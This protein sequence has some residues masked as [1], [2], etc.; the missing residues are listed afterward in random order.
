MELAWADLERRENGIGAGAAGVSATNWWGDV[1]QFLSPTIL[2][3]RTATF[4]HLPSHRD[5]YFIQL[6]ARLKLN[7][8]AGRAP[9]AGPDGIWPVA[10][11]FSSIEKWSFSDP[12]SQD[13][14]GCQ[15]REGHKML[16]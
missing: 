16:Q 2:D 8:L 6:R 7:R 9:A 14:S 5:F 15:S 11:L 13:L 10:P 3:K 4:F 1:L 12:P